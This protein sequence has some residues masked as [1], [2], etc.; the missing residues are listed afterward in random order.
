MTR[1]VLVARLRAVGLD[2]AL[3]DEAE[4]DRIARAAAELPPMPPLIAP[5]M[6]ALPCP[7]ALCAAIR[8]A[9]QRCLDAI[10]AKGAM[11][12]AFDG[13]ELRERLTAVAAA[14]GDALPAWQ[15][16]AAIW[17]EECE[18][19][20][21]EARA[22]C[23]AGQADLRRLVCLYA[24]ALIR[25]TPEAEAYPATLTAQQTH[26]RE[27]EAAIAQAERAM[28]DFASLL[29]VQATA[30]LDAAAPLFAAEERPFSPTEFRR[31][32]LSLREACTAWLSA[33]ASI[34]EPVPN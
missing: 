23:A 18:G 15:E 33:S 16:E 11:L 30:L 13:G 31:A 3:F 19:I 10:G 26:L 28:L 34:F 29:D 32:A 22:A 25:R 4:L 20:C 5:H 12:W 1:S 27:A 6:P 8:A 21:A 17:L 14:L 2:P 24:A 9:A 7:H